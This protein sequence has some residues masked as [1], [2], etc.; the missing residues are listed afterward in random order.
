[1]C[2]WLYNDVK[3]GIPFEQLPDDW[4]CPT[5]GALKKAFEKIG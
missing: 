2:K 4:K 5:C 1:M 3:E